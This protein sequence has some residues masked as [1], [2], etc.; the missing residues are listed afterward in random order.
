MWSCFNDMR[1]FARDGRYTL[2]HIVCKKP[3]VTK[4]LIQMLLDMG[5]DTN[6]PDKWGRTAVHLASIAGSHK[7]GLQFDFLLVVFLSSPS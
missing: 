4:D 7:V 5:A 1:T 3:R 2:L 6:V